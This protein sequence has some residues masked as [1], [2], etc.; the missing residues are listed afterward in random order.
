MFQQPQG[1]GFMGQPAPRRPQP[2]GPSC[3][4]V[5]KQGFAMGAVGGVC[6]GVVLGGGQT[7]M[8]GGGMKMA[9]RN[10]GMAGAGETERVFL[11]KCVC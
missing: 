2:Q 11:A 3:W 5:A 7:L 9:L 8:S 1:G 10:A 4:S 6:L